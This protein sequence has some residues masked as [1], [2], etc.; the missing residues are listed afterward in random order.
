[1]G[2]DHRGDHQGIGRRAFLAGSVGSLCALGAGR[3]SALSETSGS[4][5]NRSAR[6]DGNRK[7]LFMCVDGF[8][9]DYLTQSDMPNLKEMI[10][11]GTYVEGIDVIPSVTNVN[12]ASLITGSFPAEHGITGNYYYD[13]TTREGSFMESPEFLL[14]PTI[15]DE[16]RRRGMRS[17]FVTSKA[18]LMFL[19]GGAD[20]AVSA[21]APDADMVRTIG[22]A[23]DVY[24]PDINFWSL[25][26]AR[27]YL[28][29][30]DCQLVYVATTD[31]MMHTYPPEDERSQAHLRTLDELLGQIAND[32]RSLEVYLTADH[33]M[34]AKTEAIDI[35]RFMRDNG[36]GGE[37]VPIIRDRYIVHHNNLGG[38]C[39][40]YLDRE[41]DLER[42]EDI[43]RG[44]PGVEEIHR[45]E[46]AAREFQ[47]R[48]GRIGDL[49]V[50]GGPSVVFGDIDERREPVAIRS[51]GSRHET[52]VPIVCY[53]RSVDA[54]AYRRSLDLT[55]N[56]EWEA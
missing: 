48:A 24:S 33:G 23:Q 4:P 7:V 35:G 40:V 3:L 28:N 53:G 2:P 37:A 6:W 38:A 51:H 8:G 41:S 49:F 42:M 44:I 11:A 10:R 1:V 21:E 20:F 46:A 12:N 22:P 14:R 16:A 18:K 52:A 36:I 45:R 26:A 13:R 31:Y 29:D 19:S 9:P 25:R 30:A 43:L 15:L 54:S 27:H 47:L 56:F 55:R 50:L 5:L 34:S 32:H 17:A 39:Y